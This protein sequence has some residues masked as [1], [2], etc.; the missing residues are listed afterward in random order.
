M[1]RDVMDNDF[2]FLLQYKEAN[3]PPSYFVRKTV[4]RATFKQKKKGG[5]GERER[6][7]PHVIVVHNCTS[8]RRSPPGVTI[9][10]TVVKTSTHCF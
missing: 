9:S 10:F 3:V 2:F 8:H 1:Y 5:E 4:A 6:K 7:V